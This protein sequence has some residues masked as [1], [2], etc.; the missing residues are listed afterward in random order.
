[1]LSDTQ[2]YYLQ[3]MGVDVW[4]RR[5]LL[6]DIATESSSELDDCSWETLRER[7]ATCRACSLC[8]TRTQT[9]F[10]VGHQE[11]D[12]L[13][14]GEAPGFYEDKQGEPFVGRAGQLLDSMLAAFDL[15]RDKVY[16]ANVLK[17]RPPENRDPKPDEVAKC[18]PFLAQQVKLLK[19]KMIVALGR[20]SAHYL[21]KTSAPLNRLRDKMHHFGEDKVPLCVTYH[22]AYL[23]RSPA[24][25]R[26]A[27]QDWLSIIGSLK[28]SQ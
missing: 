1:M 14:V 16:I 28:A 19:P 7:V 6:A 8:E 27:Y 23:L 18:T 4:C 20:Y 12:L 2:T 15:N 25:K 26:K 5:E 10:G 13:L 3:Q 9:V 24:D 11:A 21:L 22:P 17:C